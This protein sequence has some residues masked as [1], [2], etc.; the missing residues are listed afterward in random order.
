[1]NTREKSLELA[2]L[3]GWD[4]QTD[5]G[6][7]TMPAP[8][9][10]ILCPYDTYLNGRAQFADILLEYTEVMHKLTSG[11]NRFWHGCKPTQANILD[12]ILRMN[13]IEI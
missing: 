1:V 12:E 13:N 11:T 9:R 5:Q 6:I 2:E 4:V 7:T 3:M 8:S 10:D